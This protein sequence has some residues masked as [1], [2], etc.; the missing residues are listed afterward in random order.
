[1]QTIVVKTQD[2]MDAIPLNFHG[3]IDIRSE[4][5]VTIKMLSYAY[6]IAFNFARS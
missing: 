1:M 2:E 6:P 3:R 5:N 4:P